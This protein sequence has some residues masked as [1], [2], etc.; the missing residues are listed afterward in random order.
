VPTKERSKAAKGKGQKFDF[1]VVSNRLPVD[2]VQAEDG[3]DQWRRSPGGLVTALAPIMAKSEGAWVGWQAAGI[4]F[5]AF[6]IA[7]D[8]ALERLQFGR[9]LAKFQLIQLSLSEI[10]G[11]ASASLALMLQFARMQES[12][13]A[14]MAQAAMV[15]ATTT[16]LARESVAQGRALLGGNGVTS[17][18]EMAKLFGD[19]EILYSY[20]GTYEINSLIVARAMTGMGA[21]V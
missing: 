1:I 12:G 17:D 2:R 3:A 19:A 16:R 20:E 6:D 4:Q 15:K 14:Q 10:L 9:P 21:F 13:T 18:Y 11:N 8:Y 5:G 7:R